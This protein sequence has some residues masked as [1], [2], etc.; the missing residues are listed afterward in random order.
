M[1]ESAVPFEIDQLTACHASLL[2]D[3]HGPERRPIPARHLDGSTEKGWLTG[4]VEN[5]VLEIASRVKGK[6]LGHFAYR[7]VSGKEDDCQIPTRVFSVLSIG[8]V[9]A[10]A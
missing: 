5:P 10:D 3:G 2:L 9:G 6:E 4:R 7:Q 1:E 8:G